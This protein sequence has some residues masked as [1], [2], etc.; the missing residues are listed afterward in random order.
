ME[1]DETRAI[2]AI[3]LLHCSAESWPRPFLSI[4]HT[5][6]HPRSWVV[7]PA[8]HGGLRGYFGEKL[9]PETDAQILCAYAT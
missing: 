8:L 1:G 5:T 9:N 2:S 7:S 6:L 4:C 3:S